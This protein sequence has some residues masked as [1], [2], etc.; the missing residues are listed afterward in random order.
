MCQ[1]RDAATGSRLTGDGDCILGILVTLHCL[2]V[3][4]KVL[5]VTLNSEDTYYKSTFFNYKALL[6]IT[7]RVKGTV[8]VGCTAIAVFP[9]N[10]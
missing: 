5:C 6:F 10:A 4:K 7:N 9:H 8:T 2:I 1:S 3:T